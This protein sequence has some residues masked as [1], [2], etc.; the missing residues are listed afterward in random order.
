MNVSILNIIDVSIDTSSKIR[1]IYCL[2]ENKTNKYIF[3]IEN[4]SFLL[5]TE[6]KKNT[7]EEI[8]NVFSIKDCLYTELN[9]NFIDEEDDISY[10]FTKFGLTSFVIKCKENLPEI[11]DIFKSINFFKEHKMQFQPSYLI[12]YETLN[13][14]FN[15]YY[16]SENKY[17]F[18]YKNYLFDI[19]IPK[20]YLMIV[21]EKHNTTI[22]YLKNEYSHFDYNK[23]K[24]KNFTIDVLKR[25]VFTNHADNTDNTDIININ[26]VTIINNQQY[27]VLT[28]YEKF[29]KHNFRVVFFNPYNKQY[30][31]LEFLRVLHFIIIE[32]IKTANFINIKKILQ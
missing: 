30:K 15:F 7:F 21:I 2:A 3:R 11:Y 5:N 26:N 4:L 6:E 31:F 20:Y 22:N 14:I 32:N 28:D 25:E 19:F 24:T 29:I 8:C 18:L 17:N 9:K 23:N 16:V 1:K 13:D 10:F 12:G 27:S